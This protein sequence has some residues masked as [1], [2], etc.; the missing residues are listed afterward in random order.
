MQSTL[1]SQQRLKLYQRRGCFSSVVPIMGSERSTLIWIRSLL[2][3][4]SQR[5]VLNGADSSWS[6]IT[7]GIQQDSVL[8]RLL[9]CINDVHDRRHQEFGQDIR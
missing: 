7:C 3:V 5:V 8:G 2:A 6:H 4:R 1:T 9:L